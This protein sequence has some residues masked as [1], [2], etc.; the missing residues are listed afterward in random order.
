VERTQAHVASGPG[1]AQTD[2]LLDYL[3]DVD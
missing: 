3:D 1:F 2:I